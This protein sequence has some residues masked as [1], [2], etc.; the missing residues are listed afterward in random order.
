M[1]APAQAETPNSNTSVSEGLR[2]Q[3]AIWQ[4]S[5]KA[6]KTK[7]STIANHPERCVSAASRKPKGAVIK[8]FLATS[9]RA[10][11]GSAL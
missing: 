6:P 9:K 1:T 11:C 3:S 2:D 7:P 8:T 10:N 4:S 5:S